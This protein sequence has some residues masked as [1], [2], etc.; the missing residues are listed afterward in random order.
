MRYV[1][2]LTAEGRVD[3]LPDPTDLGM[4]HTIGRD[5]ALKQELIDEGVWCGGQ[6]LHPSSMGT[7]VQI[8]GE[9]V[10]LHDGPFVE[11]SNHL[12]GYYLVDCHDLDHAV[13]IAARIPAAA[14]GSIDV[15]PVWD[16]E[17]LV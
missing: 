8:R 1:L 9:R 14:Y 10:V 3:D 17:A 5:A 13:E 16:F 15:R 7:G 2:L 4:Q 12:I 11:T 6:A